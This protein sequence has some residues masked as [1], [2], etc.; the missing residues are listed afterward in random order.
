LQRLQ[1]SVKTDLSGVKADLNANNEK[2]KNLQD[3][4]KIEISS[5]KADISEKF[6]QLKDSNS[7]FQED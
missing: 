3:S 7:K 6:S 1:E 5:V 2:I 4:V